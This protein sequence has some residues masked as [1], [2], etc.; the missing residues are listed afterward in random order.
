MRRDVSE[1]ALWLTDVRL[2]GDA[3]TVRVRNEGARRTKPSYPLEICPLRHTGAAGISSASCAC[4]DDS[5][6]QFARAH[7]ASVE[8][9]RRC[10]P[11][12]PRIGALREDVIG[13]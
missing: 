12:R 10:A 5:P 13:T 2:A 7:L 8:H 4:C 6:D 11:F 1:M 9:S 3:G